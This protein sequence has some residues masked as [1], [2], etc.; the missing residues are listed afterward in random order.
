MGAHPLKAKKLPLPGLAQVEPLLHWQVE[1][2]QVWSIYEQHLCHSTG[3]QPDR[4]N[5]SQ[6][7]G[8]SPLDVQ[9]EG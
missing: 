3:I 8:S 4:T 9:K 1:A 6:G 5:P 2:G 7:G